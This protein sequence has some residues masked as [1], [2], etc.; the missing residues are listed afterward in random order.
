[1]SLLLGWYAGLISLLNEKMEHSV[2]RN[3]YHQ[4]LAGEDFLYHLY[5]YVMLTKKAQ[6]LSRTAISG[7]H[8]Q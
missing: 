1:M 3:D 4:K 7:Y 8:P 6:L 5:I 2:L